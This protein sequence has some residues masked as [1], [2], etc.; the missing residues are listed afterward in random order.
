MEDRRVVGENSCNSGGG[1]DQTG[2]I[3]D[4]YDD[5]NGKSNQPLK[6]RTE[7]KLAKDVHFDHSLIIPHPTLTIN[8]WMLVSH[9]PSIT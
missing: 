8:F 6:C 4:F 3:L 5:D 2:P 1:T 7:L 9:M